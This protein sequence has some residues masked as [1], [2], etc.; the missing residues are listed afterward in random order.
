MAKPG[1][2][3]GSRNRR[4]RLGEAAIRALERRGEVSAARVLVK[5]QAIAEDERH[6]LCVAA[7]KVILS[8]TLGTPKA[9]LRLE[10]D[11]GPNIREVLAE[12]AA[13]RRA[14]QLAEGT[15]ITVEALPA[16]NS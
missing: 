4:S 7:A 1:R 11:T 5:L 2:P 12:I 8:Y 9:T 15:A 10:H 16:G 6:P 13:E 3:T 14:R